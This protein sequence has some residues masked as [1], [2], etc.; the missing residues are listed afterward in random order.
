MKSKKLSG[1]LSVSESGVVGGY[2]DGLGF[3]CALIKSS[4]ASPGAWIIAGSGCIKGPEVSTD[5]AAL[6]SEFVLKGIDKES[7]KAT[8]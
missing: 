6:I 1:P 8:L 7:R 4:N 2:R 3:R 5:L